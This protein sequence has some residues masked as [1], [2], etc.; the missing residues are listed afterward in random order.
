MEQK[1]ITTRSS[2]GSQPSNIK[3]RFVFGY[4]L[5]SPKHFPSYQEDIDAIIRILSQAIKNVETDR[6]FDIWMLSHPDRGQYS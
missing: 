1:E 2:Q 4:I 6:R 5:A 3:Q